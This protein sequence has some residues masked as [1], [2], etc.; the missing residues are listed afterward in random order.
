MFGR[1]FWGSLEPL[2]LRNMLF[3]RMFLVCLSEPA[4][5]C[6]SIFLE[7]LDVLYIENSTLNIFEI[8]LYI[9]IS[10]NLVYSETNFTKEI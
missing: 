6:F 5:D 10:D 9:M 4:K 3:K 7:H 1:F 8:N 2:Y